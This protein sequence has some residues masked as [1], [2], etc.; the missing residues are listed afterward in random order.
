MRTNYKRKYRNYRN[1]SCIS[2]DLNGL[3]ALDA[4]GPRFEVPKVIV[5][6]CELKQERS[7]DVRGNESTTLS[8]LTGLPPSFSANVNAGSLGAWPSAASDLGN[9][10]PASSRG[11]WSQHWAALQGMCLLLRPQWPRTGQEDGPTKGCQ[12]SRCHG[13]C[14]VVV[15]IRFESLEFR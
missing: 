1:I 7:R 11:K 2:V 12:V 6:F 4:L 3:D 5:L 10:E 9:S 13:V 8:L 15:V 14:S